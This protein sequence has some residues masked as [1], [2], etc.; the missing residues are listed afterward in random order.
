MQ[1]QPAQ[2]NQLQRSQES[3][4]TS[5]A[6]KRNEARG[7]ITSPAPYTLFQARLRHRLIP[8]FLGH[9]VQMD[10]APAEPP[11]GQ[12]HAQTHAYPR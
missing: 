11:A 5:P 1:I 2:R 8:L 3:K 12:A 6:P 7:K 4:I 9:N 10:K